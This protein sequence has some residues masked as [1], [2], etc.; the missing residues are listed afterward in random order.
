MTLRHGGALDLLNGPFDEAAHTVDV[1]RANSLRTGGR[2]NIPSAAVSVWRLKIYSVSET[3]AYC[4]D[5]RQGC[6]TFSVLGNDTHLYN[7]AQAETEPTHIAEELNL[8]TAIRRRRFE[9]HKTDY[10]GEGK[11]LYMSIGSPR[12]PVPADRVI[13]ANLTDWVYRSDDGIAVDPCLAGLS[14]HQAIRHRKKLF[15]YLTATLLALT[16]AVV[17]TIDRSR[18]RLTMI[19]T[20][21]GNRR[22]IRRSM[23]P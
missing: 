8:P 1:R 11:S 15:G 6:Y 13:P 2:Y 21:L 16:L 5:E 17:S 23:T 7:N 3:P 19:S 9:K 10:Y 12:Q 22:L 4:V 18:S 20:G 14:F